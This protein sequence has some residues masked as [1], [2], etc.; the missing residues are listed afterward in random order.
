G[1]ASETGAGDDRVWTHTPGEPRRRLDDQP[2]GAGTDE[3]GRSPCEQHDS[4]AHV[5][6]LTA[7]VALEPK[8]RCSP[9]VRASR[10]MRKPPA[11]LSRPATRTTMS[12]PVD[13]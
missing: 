1:A 3:R 12:P 8:T 2:G 11:K 10:A 7:T 6:S 4:R 5:R 13:R 9:R